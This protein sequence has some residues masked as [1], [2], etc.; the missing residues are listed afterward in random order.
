MLIAI[1][2]F[3]ILTKQKGNKN[4]KAILNTKRE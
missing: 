1:D 2:I 3:Q 4:A